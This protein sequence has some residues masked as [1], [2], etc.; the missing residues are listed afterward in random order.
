MNL[1]YFL[2]P[3]A[4]SAF[5][6]LLGTLLSVSAA[7]ERPNIIVLVADD[8][9]WDTLG[10]MGNRI[11]Q[12]PNLDR[13]A[14][15]GVMFRNAYVTT[16]ICCISRASI[17]TGQYAARH[18][19][20]NF[21]DPLSPEA[22]AMTY[23]LLLRDA[24]YRTAFIGKY[25]VGGK[26]P[27]PKDDFDYWWATAHQPKYENPQPDGSIKHYTDLVTEHAR[28]FLETCDGK[29]PFCMSISYKA[30]HVEDSDPRQFIYNQRYKE[31]YAN[32]TIPPAKNGTD[33]YFNRLP[34][35]LATE[36][37]EAR[38]RWHM[39]FEEDKYQEMVKGYY[40]LITGIDDSVASIRKDLIERGLSEN[41]IILFIG[42]HGFYL[43]EH[44]MAGK[45]YGHE[46]SIRVPLIVF[47]PR[48]GVTKPKQKRDE[49]VLNIDLAPTVLEL[50]KVEVP[51][52]MQGRSLMP[53]LRGESPNWR[54][55][56]FYE[57]KFE[58]ARIPRSEGVVSAKWKYL[59]YID[60]E[61]VQEE[62]YN[63]QLDS[64]EVTNLVNDARY[65]DQ[66]SR[67]RIQC[68]ALAQGAM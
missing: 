24:G 35:C 29:Q 44:G 65:A 64:G 50:A 12:T 27:L 26:G 42:D 30:P 14:N 48:K 9:R 45:W 25:G 52:V 11:I 41:T 19:I 57:H 3:R 10:A 59:R 47:D 55:S 43:G 20:L 6:L 23:P 36:E 53:I 56:F 67:L 39:R 22:L 63:L 2:R 1:P 49:M 28:E 5:A 60:T 68:A 15:E 17:L 13:L 34:E 37:N 51:D 18:G 21:A 4:V 8:Q 33:E 62:L 54:S 38:V 32:I 40:R 31:L 66:L 7:A 58:H 46:V 61:P 16:A